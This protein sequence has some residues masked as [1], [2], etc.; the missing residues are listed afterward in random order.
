MSEQ[1]PLAGPPAGPWRR[2]FLDA[3]VVEQQRGLERVFH[4][5]KKFPGNPVIRA[6][7]PWEKYHS[8]GG[9]YLYGTVMWDGGKLC[10]WY[11]VHNGGYMNCYAESTDGIHWT[12]PN[13]GLVEYLGSKANNIF[14]WR[15]ADPNEHPPY[16]YSGRCHNPSVIKRPW[17]AD[18][19]K[20]Y[21]L[22]C[23]GADYRHARV[24][25]S[26]DGLRWTFAPETAKRG[27]FRSS[28]VLNFFY[29]PYKARYVATWKTSSRRGRAVGVAVS[30]DGLKWTKPVQGPVFTADD[31]DPDATQIY[32]MPVFPYQGLYI[33]LAWIYNARWF[34]YGSYADQRMY[35]VEKD[36]PC[37]VDV[38]LAWSW[39]LINWT[40]PPRRKPFIPRG[41]PG[42]FDSGM[43]YTARAPVLVNDQLYFYYG[44][45][46]GPHN[47]PKSKANI[48]L[49]V[50][51]LDGF[52]SLRAGEREGWFISR[53]E[54]FYVP[55]VAINARTRDDGY[56]AAEILDTNNR[57]IPGFTRRECIPFRGDSVRHVLTWKTE[58]LPAAYRDADKKLRF[59]LKNADLYSYLP[60]QTA[61]PATIIYD[62]AANG[63][64]LPDDPAIPAAQRF[65]LS[66][67]RGGFRIVRERGVTYLDMHSLAAR[68]T[69]ACAFKDLDWTDDADWT[70]E[71]TC[72]VAD[73]GT[74]PN[75]GLAVFVRPNAGRNAALYLSDKAT[76]V[77]STKAGRHITLKTVPMDTTDA[78][79]RYRLAHRG[80]AKG[81]IVLFVDG[82]EA[83][84]LPFEKLFVSR[85]RGRNL[86]F[87]PNAAQREGRLHVARF[88]FRTGS[89][90]ARREPARKTR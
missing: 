83:L 63:G 87:G 23:Y 62:P 10:M 24:A 67:W 77:L 18:P 89:A 31:L 75:Y 56:V 42:E 19:A 60:D 32:G 4:A 48:G 26:P 17:V 49:A 72:R 73:A 15:G 90:A 51:R 70:M 3:M 25:F 55:K 7:K 9:P 54:P 12:K 6:D 30:K 41:K 22:F 34:K 59:Y 58:S 21:A 61:A 57:P 28:D 88:S 85:V 8:Y 64:R 71:I 65:A 1:D 47:S 52:C 44:G 50:L 16:V 66:G 82:K 13:L 33:G 80:G 2:L 35:E 81:E 84:R 79:H 29:D 37:T 39:D 46:D 69:N 36:S 76:G 38:Q 68:K 78:F 11:H 53:R 43:I 5:A 14:L 45:W 27:L 74:E 20:R 40:R 86:V